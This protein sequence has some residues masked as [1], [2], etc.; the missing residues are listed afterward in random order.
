MKYFFTY[1]PLSEIEK[2]KDNLN[3]SDYLISTEWKKFRDKIVE[4][5]NSQCRIC[6]R[7]EFFADKLDAFRE[8][9]DKEKSEYLEKIK[10]EFLKSELGKDWVKIFGSLPKFGIPMVPKEEF[11]NYESVILNVHHQYYIKGKK[12]WEYNPNSLETVCSDCHTE[13]HNTQTIQVYEDDSKID[14]KPFIN[15]WKCKGT[16]YLP[17]YNYVMN[18]VCFECQGKGRKE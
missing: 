4:R 14:S 10:K 16:G 2:E 1:K 7:K 17:K 13:I 8:M 5:D 3:Y 9:T 11:N 6:Q 15:C 18:G 12:P